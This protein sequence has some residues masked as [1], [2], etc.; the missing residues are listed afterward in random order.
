M[1]SNVDRM[2]NNLAPDIERKCKELQAARK[3]RLQTRIF[4]LLC[5]MVVIVPALLIFAGVSLTVL[6]APLIFMSLS[7][8]LLLPVLLSGKTA[9][10]GGIVYEQA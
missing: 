8:V 6:I 7:V 9:N 4:A 2:L 5:A 10:Q 1:T 3:E